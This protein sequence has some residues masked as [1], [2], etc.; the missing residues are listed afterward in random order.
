MRGLHALVDQARDMAAVYPDCLSTGQ[1][2]VEF[3]DL[4]PYYSH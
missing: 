4:T 1:F 2:A 3:I